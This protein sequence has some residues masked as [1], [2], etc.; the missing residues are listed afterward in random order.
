MFFAGSCNKSFANLDL[1]IEIFRVVY[2]TDFSCCFRDTY[3][4]NRQFILDVSY[5]NQVFASSIYS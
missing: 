3:V 2:L 5:R 1:V 4:C